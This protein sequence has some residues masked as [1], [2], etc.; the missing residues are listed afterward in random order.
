MAVIAHDT[1]PL[2]PNRR[3]RRKFPQRTNAR[4]FAKERIRDAVISELPPKQGCNA[5]HSSDNAA[6]AWHLIEVFAPELME[7]VRERLD[8]RVDAQMAFPE[9]RQAA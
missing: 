5:L 2:S 9:T 6:E 1:N 4:I 3:Q 7:Q 8:E